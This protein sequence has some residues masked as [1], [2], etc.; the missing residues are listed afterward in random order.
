VK[1]RSKLQSF[2]PGLRKMALRK[3]LNKALS[4]E[5]FKLHPTVLYKS[6][7]N[8]DLLLIVSFFAVA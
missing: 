1:K 2:E 5:D 4:S 6:W 7:L 3:R 8:K